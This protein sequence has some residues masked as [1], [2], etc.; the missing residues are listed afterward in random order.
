M[1]IAYQG[2]LNHPDQAVRH[3]AAQCLGRLC[4]VAG[5]D[6][7]SR[8]VS[9]LINQVVEDRDPNM[10]SGCAMAFGCINAELGGMAAGFHLKNIHGILTSLASDPHPTVHYWALDGLSKIADSAG[11]AFSGYVS[12]TLGMLAQLYVAESHGEEGSSLGTSN[13]EIDF[14][15]VTAIARCLDS[16]INVLGPDLQD[17]TKAR[18]MILTLTYQFQT[19]TSLHVASESLKCL[20]NLSMYAPGHISFGPYVRQLQDKLG[21]DDPGVQRT[22]L[23]GLYNSMR[24]DAEEVLSVAGQSLE[25]QMWLLLHAMHGQGILRNIIKDWVEQSGVQEL[26]KWVPR[27]QAILTKVRSQKMKAPPK[28][29]TTRSIEAELQDEEVAGFAAAA[30]ETAKDDPNVPSEASQELLRWQVR[31]TAME[32]L[33]EI[34]FAVAREVSNH[35]NSSHIPSL[36]SRIA[37]IVRIA[38]SASTAS[39]VELRIQGIQIIGKVLQVRTLASPN[40][41]ESH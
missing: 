16:V 20:E 11:L 31:Y 8:E 1:L 34:L 33:N 32:S 17:M 10:R 21:S 14:P 3:L 27:V 6:F 12:G 5:K 28:T 35:G 30:S 15:S 4:K 37:D 7:T 18:N 25:D 41:C 29:L 13:T 19:E 2:F 40:T 38:F 22:A 24:Q 36:Q 9:Y 23:T 39:V 26:E